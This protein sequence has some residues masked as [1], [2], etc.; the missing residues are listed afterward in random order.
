MAKDQ[1]YTLAMIDRAVLGNIIFPVGRFNKNQTRKM[2]KS[3]GLEIS[4]KPDSQEICFI[5]DNDYTAR[6]ETLCP[7]LVRQG[8][9]ID[10]S[11]R[12]LGT[13]NGIHHFTIGQRRGLKIAMGVPWY[14]TKLDASQNTVTLGPEQE[15]LHKGLSATEPNWLIDRPSEA[16]AALI[17]TRYNDKPVP[18]CVYPDEQIIKVIFDQPILA[19]TPG[20]AVVFYLKNEKGLKVAGSAWIKETF[21]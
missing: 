5:P 13:H 21:D 10:S 12:I 17:K 14:V 18:G 2:A 8:N 19:A 9:I 4:S 1:S 7:Q 20:Q 6:L 15:L 3:F 16:F 11:G